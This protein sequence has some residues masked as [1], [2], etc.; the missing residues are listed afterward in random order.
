MLLVIAKRVTPVPDNSRKDLLAYFAGT[1]TL[2]AVSFAENELF[3]ATP[4]LSISEL[5]HF[6]NGLHQ[7]YLS[8]HA[9]PPTP[10]CWRMA[11]EILRQ[12]HDAS[13]P[14]GETWQAYR[15]IDSAR[16]LQ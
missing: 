9:F 2:V 10:I 12:E 1:K 14:E 6:P 15:H 7:P 11:A 3:R 13:H 8:L 16:A 4:L 5:L